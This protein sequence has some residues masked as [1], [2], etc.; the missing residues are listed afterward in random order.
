LRDGVRVVVADEHA[1]AVDVRR[2][3]SVCGC[4]AGAVSFELRDEPRICARDVF[5]ITA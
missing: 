4:D 5:E 3:A 1:Q 2:P